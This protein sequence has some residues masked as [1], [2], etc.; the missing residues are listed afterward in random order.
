MFNRLYEQKESLKES[1]RQQ[2]MKVKNKCF[3][4]SKQA[5]ATIKALRK[6]IEPFRR[7]IANRD[8]TIATQDKQLRIQSVRI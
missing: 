3:Y 6:T 5:E 1:Y 7:E 4:D 2:Y 8:G